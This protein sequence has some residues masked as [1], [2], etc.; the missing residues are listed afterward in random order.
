MNRKQRRHPETVARWDEE[1]DRVQEMRAEALRE[2]MP[3]EYFRQR[4]AAVAK[5]Q[6]NGI[7][8]KELK[9]NYDRG[10]S[11]GF[12]AAGEPIVKGCFAAICLALHDKRFGFGKKRCC[13]V[14]NAVDQHL[15]YDLT[16]DEAIEQVWQEIGLK[17]D[18]KEAFDRIQEI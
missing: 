11:D 12:K 3:E 10:F 18:F 9:E 7:T 5:I 2:C 1:F 14:L 8:I 16:S 17:L 15:L 13:D 4:V 6:Q